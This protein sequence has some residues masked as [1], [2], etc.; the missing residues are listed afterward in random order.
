MKKFLLLV[1]CLLSAWA[2]QASLRHA[3]YRWRNDDGGEATATWK[4][5]SNTPIFVDDIDEILRVRFEFDNDNGSG[6]ASEVDHFLWYSKDGGGTWT[7]ITNSDV[8]DFKMVNSGFV[9]HGTPTTNLLGT[10]LGT[11]SGGFVI[12]DELPDMSALINDGQRLEMEWVIQPTINCENFTTY[13]FEMTYWETSGVRAQ[14]STNFDCEEPVVTVAPTFERCG[15]GTFILEAEVD[16]EDAII[17]WWDSPTSGMLVGTGSSFETAIMTT[18]TTLYAEGFHEGCMSDRIPVELIV[19]EVPIINI[20]LDDGAHCAKPEELDVVSTPIQPEGTTYLWHN[21]ATTPNILLPALPT[22]LRTIWIEVTNQW[23]C[24]A[25]DTAR[26]IVNP[27]PIVDLGPDQTVCEGGV[28]TLDAGNEG[29]AYYWNV[30][31]ATQELVVDDG[32]TYAVLVTNEYGCTSSDTIQVNIEGF[33]PSVRGIQVD[34]ISETRFR[35][36]PLGPENVTSYSWDF[37]DD[38]PP[39]VMVAPDHYYEEPGTYLVTLE[40]QSSCGAREYFAYATIVLGIDEQLAGTQLK[41]YPNPATNTVQVATDNHTQIET[42]RIV[43]SLG[44]EVLMHDAGAT[45]MTTMDISALPSGSY[46]L[47]IK[48]NKGKAM[49]RLQIVR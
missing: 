11:F 27:A 21:G 40:V 31:A 12:S 19:R 2:T 6:L 39:S 20:P 17:N 47:E 41:V 38:S 13:L 15:P 3:E 36:T 45:E 7:Q 25:S 8:N 14:L 23:G 33:A 32:G 5:A 43:N 4:A 44:Q 10:G 24:I 29:S 26:I 9:A 49:Q 48:T 18:G 35:F 1:I 30:G 22:T 42:V 34:H 16:M 37:G 46:F 28:V